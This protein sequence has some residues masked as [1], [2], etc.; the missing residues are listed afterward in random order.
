MKA[1][2]HYEFGGPNVLNYEEIKT[3]QPSEG[4]VLVK[5]LAVAIDY[6]QLH[7]RHGGSGRVGSLQQSSYGI[8][9]APY[10]PGGM[11]CVE[12]VASGV[13]VEG[14]KAGTRHLVGGLRPGS[15]AEF[16]V[17]DAKGL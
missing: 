9:D 17:V 2:L 4:E 12:V 15:Y 1:V 13:A 8:T 16:G 14:V 3:P 5:V 11:A 7:I 10:F 6:I